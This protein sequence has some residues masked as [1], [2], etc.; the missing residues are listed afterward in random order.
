MP[1]KDKI[2]YN[3]KVFV[4]PPSVPVHKL[5]FDKLNENLERVADVEWLVNGDTGESI[6]Y[7]EIIPLV[8]KLSSYLKEKGFQPGDVLMLY[9]ANHRYFFLPI[10]SA[11]SCGGGATSICPGALPSS[12]IHLAIHSKTKF[13]IVD[14]C[15][16][17]KAKEVMQKVDTIV[18]IITLESEVEGCTPLSKIFENGKEDV[19]G[20]IDIDVD[21]TVAYLPYSSGTTGL[22]K[23]IIHTHRSVGAMLQIQLEL[24]IG[25]DFAIGVHMYY[26]SGFYICTSSLLTFSRIIFLKNYEEETFLRMLEKYQPSFLLSLPFPLIMMI[27]HPNLEDYNLESLKVISTGGAFMSSENQRAL[28]K[29][30]PGLQDVRSLYAMTETGGITSF[31]KGISAD[32]REKHRASVGTPYPG[33]E[34][35]VIDENGIEL[36]PYEKGEICVRN[37]SSMKEYLHNPEATRNAKIDGGWIKTGDYGYYTEDGFIYCEGR[38]NELINY[39]GH[40]IVPTMLESMLLQH[41]AVKDAGVIGI[42]DKEVGESVGAAII[43]QD[44]ANVDVTDILSYMNS[45]LSQNEKPRAG[46][47]VFKT[48]P[49]SDAGKL[50]KNQLLKDWT[51][52]CD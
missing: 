21:N 36:G 51:S 15:T 40:Y 3:E 42:P 37:S 9:C 23:G 5:L 12:A 39:K 16:A 6:K 47:K 14:D 38:K 35:K 24:E 18:E 52:D 17:G 44:N 50:F 45:L 30:L 33:N 7:G 28:M 2:V 29:R 13:I 26:I 22:A 48:L 34:V 4:P 1:V 41:P 20:D 19:E 31:E 25:T 46:V 11:W 10:F 43:L 8:N 32:I 27:K 49:Y